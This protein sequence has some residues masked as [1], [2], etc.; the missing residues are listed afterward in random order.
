MTRRTHGIRTTT[1]TGPALLLLGL[2]FVAAGC[3]Q[4]ERQTTAR[5]AAQVA[6][7]SVTTTATGQSTTTTTPR[8]GS[9]GIKPNGRGGFDMSQAQKNALARMHYIRD[10]HNEAFKAFRPTTQPTS[11]PATIIPTR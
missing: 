3:T 8:R 1:L 5:S 2:L 4:E 6:A 7:A 11:R 10:H 9:S